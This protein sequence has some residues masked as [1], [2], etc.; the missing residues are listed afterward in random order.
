MANICT[1]T[2]FVEGEKKSIEELNT[3]FDETMSNKNNLNDEVNDNNSWIGNLLLNKGLFP[4]KYDTHRAFICDY[5][6]ENDTTFH[7]LMES[8]WDE[9]MEAMD[10]VFDSVDENMKSYYFAEECLM[11]YYVSNDVDNKYFGDYYV[12]WLEEDYNLAVSSGELKRF[13]ELIGD[14]TFYTAKELRWSL[15]KLLHDPFTKLDKLIEKINDREEYDPEK[16]GISL[17][18]HKIKKVTK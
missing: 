15:A 4:Y 9:K 8:A 3:L 18:I 2:I 10:A 5:G 16:T 7:V 6:E 13:R 11:E 14:E 12:D 17:G 1:T